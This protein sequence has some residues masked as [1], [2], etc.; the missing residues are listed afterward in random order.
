M[1][2]LPNQGTMLSLGQNEPLPP[3][4]SEWP[5]YH[6]RDA[7]TNPPLDVYGAN[8]AEAIELP[9]SLKLRPAAEPNAKFNK[10]EEPVRRTL[11]TSAALNLSMSGVGGV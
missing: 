6:G 7:G 2:P 10:I 4:S 5:E 11:R 9:E 8:R 1:L 3:I